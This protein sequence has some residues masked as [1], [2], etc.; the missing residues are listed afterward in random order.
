MKHIDL[1]Q[2]KRW[3]SFILVLLLTTGCTTVQPWEKNH[4]AKP[5]MTWQADALQGS[6]HSHIYH[7]KEGS[8][9]SNSTAGGGCGCN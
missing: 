4:L 3:F 9:G 1:S 5:E 8:S 2:A 6:L 7:S